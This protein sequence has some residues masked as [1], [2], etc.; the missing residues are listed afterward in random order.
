MAVS[1]SRGPAALRSEE[2]RCADWLGISAKSDQSAPVSGASL[3]LGRFIGTRYYRPPHPRREVW[4]EDM[5]R[6]RSSGLKLVRA[7]LY[8]SKVN[9]KP[10][11]WTF[12]EYDEFVELARRHGL[13]V[14][15]QLAPE[16]APQWF[17][18]RHED[19]CYVDVMGAKVAR[20]RAV[21]CQ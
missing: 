5:E 16:S 20:R 17:I 6:I 2:G 13:H 15:I 12:S 3:P 18:E 8:W 7:W 9:P 11:L 10:G 1:V 4:S 21:W 19:A 14:L